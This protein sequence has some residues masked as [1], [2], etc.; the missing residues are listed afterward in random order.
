MAGQRTAASD[1]AI[2]RGDG[3]QPDSAAGFRTKCFFTQSRPV[4]K[5]A[6]PMLEQ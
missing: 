4:V 3:R 2:A 5:Y 6:A 1:Q